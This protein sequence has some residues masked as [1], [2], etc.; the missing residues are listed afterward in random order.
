MKFKIVFIAILIFCNHFV[1]GQELK[2]EYQK[3]IANFIDCVKNDRKKDISEMITYPF[4]REYPLPEIKNKQEFMKRYDEIFDKKLKNKITQSKPSKDWS[5]V[6]WRG[7]MLYD[8]DLWID[9]DG[10][11]IT[12]NYQSKVESNLRTKIIEAEK[13]TLHSSIAQYK[14]PNYILETNK[15]R[16]RIDEIS[17]DNYRYC[18]WGLKNLISKK[19]DLII[20]NG[21][22]IPDG[23]GGN[24]Y[25]EFK[26]GDYTYEC[27]IIVMG[28]DNSPPARL[29]IS[30]NGKEILSQDVKKLKG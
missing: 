19:P 26:S 27:S 28:E 8:G 20:Y 13:K 6:G 9:T 11:L 16:I 21:K 15:F 24:H 23:S 29:T 1:F 22:W 30:K 2:K 25:F 14:N 17:P 7:I 10:R 3:K 4:R 5:E 18:S 12:I